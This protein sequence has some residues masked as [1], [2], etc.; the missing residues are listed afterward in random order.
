MR[1]KFKLILI[2]TGVFPILSW[3]QGPCEFDVVLG[4]YFQC[5]NEN[6]FYL[7]ILAQPTG[8]Y[9]GEFVTPDGFFDANA[10]GS[11]PHYVIYT[12][13]PDVCIGSD[14]VDFFILQ[15]GFLEI[16]GGPTSICAGDSTTLSAPNDFEYDWLGNGDRQNSFTF[17]PDTTTT[18]LVSGLDF[19]GCPNTLELTITVYQFG[20]DLQIAGPAYVCYGDTAT[21]EV[22]GVTELVWNDG[23]INAFFTMAMYQDTIFTA[24]IGQNTSCDTTIQLSV[25]VGEPITYEYE[26]IQEVCYGDLFQIFITGG[27]A[28][29]YKF[30]GQNFT[31]YAEYFLED[32]AILTLEAYNDSGCV[33]TRDIEFTVHEYPEF[34]I[35]APEQ[36]CGQDSVYIVV[37][38]VPS[39][40]W[41]DL[42]TGSQVPLEV[43]NEY[44]GI[45]E[46]SIQFQI[47]ASSPFGCTTT[48][49]VEI[50]VYPYPEVRI[51][52][53]T[54]FCINRMATV[55]GTGADFYLW[56]GLEFVDEI[57]FPVE[58]DTTLILFGS[59]V[60]GCYA[61]DTLEITA[62]PN[63]EIFLTGEYYVCELDTATLVGSGADIYIW[64]G[65]LGLDTLNSTPS[66]DTL[67]TLIGKNIFGCADTATY[68]V[69]VDPAPVNSFMGDSEICFG[70]SVS[71]QFITNGLVFQWADGSIQPV[72]PVNPVDD[73]T[74]TVTST[75]ANGCPRTSSF[76]VTVHDYPSLTIEGSTTVCFGDTLSLI[77]YGADEFSWNNGLSGDTIN[78]VPVATG[79]LRVDGNSNDCVTQELVAITVNT[80]PSVQFEFYADTLCTS[81]Q[82]VSW[83]AS[84][85]G[86]VLSGDGVVNN[87]FS[88][89]AALNGV[90][91]VTYTY[92]NA[93]D[94]TAAASDEIMVETCIGTEEMGKLQMSA[95]PNPCNGQFKL[96]MAAERCEVAIHNALGAMVWSGVAYPGLVIDSQTWAAGTY[97]IHA[98]G[99]ASIAPQ[100]IIKL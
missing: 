80:V 17:S 90:N 71:L 34:L 47:S 62:H 68:F 52:S 45:A 9:S 4:S 10:A 42:T 26:A 93:F 8:T 36:L 66:Y 97:T 100:R 23:S 38:G 48:E 6:G 98:V 15:E 63:P 75:G 22:P 40:D 25:D 56:N 37:T 35:E 81:G 50:F 39:T 64:D 59:T 3:S 92:T 19:T 24:S 73:T 60:Y 87:W 53:L 88:I 2:L 76:D 96:W 51:D 69:D 44:A 94:C 79:I 18:Y 65:V 11:G 54:P 85:G 74:Y 49:I 70:D 86:G 77:A 83:V 21:Y 82:G 28:A 91:T 32:D 57:S 55:F 13:D 12:A 33:V 89:E 72:I 29:Y 67:F 14:T 16:E 43:P 20:S 27:N 99:N 61:T 41:L 31:E 7:P 58:G 84:P 46:D 5:P 1:H 95:F 30:A 78:Y